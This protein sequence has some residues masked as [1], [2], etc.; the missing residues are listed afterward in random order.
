MVSYHLYLIQK[1]RIIIFVFIS[2]INSPLFDF[3]FSIHITSRSAFTA[4]YA[5]IFYFTH[6]FT[7][8]TVMNIYLFIISFNLRLHFLIIASNHFYNFIENPILFM[9]NQILNIIL[10]CL[11][12][13]FKYLNK[14][15]L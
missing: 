7:F 14:L 13:H 10:F 5:I 12:I 1:R 9:Q 6:L 4:N 2:N 3:C 15:S 11:S 8:I